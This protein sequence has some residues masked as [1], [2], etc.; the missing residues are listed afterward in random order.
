VLQLLCSLDSSGQDGERLV[1]IARLPVE[2]A[3]DI[4]A[5]EDQREVVEVLEARPS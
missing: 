4:I 1:T 3:T 2:I 5:R